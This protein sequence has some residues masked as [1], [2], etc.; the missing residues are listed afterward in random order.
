[1]GDVNN[2]ISDEQPQQAIERSA[3]GNHKRKGLN[4]SSDHFMNLNSSKNENNKDQPQNKPSKWVKMMK[5]DLIWCWFCFI[6]RKIIRKNLY[7]SVKQADQPQEKEHFEPKAPQDFSDLVANNIKQK[8]GEE[9]N[10]NSGLFHLHGLSNLHNFENIEEADKES[11][12]SP[13]QK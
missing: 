13:S 8:E 12:S 3:M 2:I 11:C 6:H 10:E 5:E 1:M 9:N 4:K 7:N